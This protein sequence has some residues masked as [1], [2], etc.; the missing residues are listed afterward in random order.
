M[1][2]N[3]ASTKSSVVPVLPAAGRGKLE[4]VC[5]V[6]TRMT[7]RSIAMAVSALCCE[8]TRARC[9]VLRSITLAGGVLDAADRDRRQRRVGHLAG[10]GP[11]HVQRA[12]HAHALVRER[13]VG[14]RHLDRRAAVPQAAERDGGVGADRARDAHQVRD[15]AD[16]LRADA[17]RELREDRVVGERRRRRQRYRAAVGAVVVLHRPGRVGPAARP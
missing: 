7:L 8:T 14:E 4:I 16:P 5:A 10:A 9:G 17:Q 13:G 2:T 15:A 12:G 11:A 1:P 3:Q 6:P